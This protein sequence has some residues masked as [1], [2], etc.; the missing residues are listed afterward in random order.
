MNVLAKLMPEVNQRVQMTTIADDLLALF[1]RYI[2]AGDSE[3]IVLAVWTLHTH[4]FGA[5]Y[6]TPYLAITSAEKQ[7]G[8]TRVLEVLKSVVRDPQ[9][10]ASISPAALARSVAE[11]RPTLLLDE[12]DALLK[13]DKEMSEALRGILNSGFQADGA[14]TRMVG[15]G[16]SMKPEHFPTFSPK[17]MAGIGTLPDTVAD[18][19]I[20]IRLER[21]PRGTCPKFRPRGLGKKSKQ[22]QHELDGLRQKAAAWASEHLKRLADSEPDCP[23]EFSDRQQDIAEPLL[24]IADA[25][26]EEWPEQVRGALVELFAS[27]AAEDSSIRVRLLRDIREIFEAEQLD[28]IG[29]DD[30][31]RKLG[32][33]E[34]SPW[35]EWR[36]GKPMSARALAEQL[37]P[38]NIVPRTIRLEDGTKKGYLRENF[39]SI[40]ERYVTD[41]NPSRYGS[42][43]AVSSNVYAGCDAVTDKKGGTAE[44]GLPSCR[45]CGSFA[46]Y[47]TPTG[48]QCETCEAL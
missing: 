46:L 2:C 36:Q 37:K 30:L 13:G 8:K 1:H 23:S 7:S 44:R 39:L 10:T 11:R 4:A 12:L 35:G 27:K 47:K 38:F 16:A 15:V 28:K 26:G 6:Y 33:I 24:A 48:L 22:L 5:S 32:E 42:K 21:S 19:S 17:A 40:W 29:S 9:I 34:T 31:V 41:K 20:T 43:S 3:L 14:F 25:L 45:K 18:R